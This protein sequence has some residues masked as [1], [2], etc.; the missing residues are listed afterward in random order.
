MTQEDIDR[1]QL[2]FVDAALRARDV[3][4]DVVDVLAGY[5]YL[6]AQFLSP[7]HNQRTDRYGG[8]LESRARF[9]LETLS[10]VRDAVGADCAIATRVAIQ[11]DGPWGHTV[12]DTVALVR[13]AD[14]LVDVWNLNLGSVLDWGSDISPPRTVPEGRNLELLGWYAGLRVNP[15]WECRD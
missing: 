1:V 15:S 5:G 9:W 14:S 4:Y 10:R 8:S 12:D 6:A 11:T 13:M 3:G 7:F 2:A